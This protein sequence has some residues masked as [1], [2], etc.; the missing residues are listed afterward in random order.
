MVKIEDDS[1]SIRSQHQ[2]KTFKFRLDV[3]KMSINMEPS[4]AVKL[5]FDFIVRSLDSTLSSY[6]PTR[7]HR[8]I[9][10]HEIVET[11]DSTL[12][13]MGIRPSQF[14][15]HNLDIFGYYD[16]YYL[17]M[18]D[19][20]HTIN[21]SRLHD[22]NPFLNTHSDDPLRVGRFRYP[23]E[24]IQLLE[25][26]PAVQMFEAIL[27]RNSPEI[28]RLLEGG[29]HL[30]QVYSHRFVY[31]YLAKSDPNLFLDIL[32]YGSRGS[33]PLRSDIWIELAIANSNIPVLEWFRDRDWTIS[34]AAGLYPFYEFES[35]QYPEVFRVLLSPTASRRRWIPL[36][37]TQ[38]PIERIFDLTSHA[39][40][41]LSATRF[42][43][44]YYSLRKDIAEKYTEIVT[45]LCQMVIDFEIPIL[46]SYIRKHPSLSEFEFQLGA[47]NVE[48]EMITT[49]LTM[50]D[51][52]PTS[53]M[54]CDS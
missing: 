13:T 53:Q 36:S 1:S 47:S 30:G 45:I 23:S 12:R 27:T 41:Q 54:V 34:I 16:Y 28:Y 19:D 5:A 29:W 20:Y 24:I 43:D 25:P 35:N 10:N 37:Y 38:L 51:I 17:F 33:Q 14:W 11:I 2:S 48:V 44:F 40:H 26:L 3:N 4:L 18:N 21:S 22:D 8:M 46:L 9:G 39:R 31:Y 49:H 6:S 50:M 42:D 32:R 7:V 15:I 52:S